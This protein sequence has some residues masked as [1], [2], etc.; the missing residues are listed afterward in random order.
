MSASEN[1]DRQIADLKDWRGAKLAD[2][3][4]LINAADP[5]LA[6]DWKWGSPVWT[7]KGNVCSIGAFKEHVKINFFKG[8][9]LADPRG[10]FNAG[11]DAKET[12]SV[13]LRE[14]EGLDEVALQD[15]VRAATNLND[16][17]SR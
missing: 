4:R 6:E 15:L 17:R 5:R 16:A 11:L 13:D 1:I 2:L 3:R 8:A 12:R 14:G 9:S 7:H 10:L